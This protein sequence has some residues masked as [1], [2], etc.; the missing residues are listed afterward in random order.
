MPSVSLPAAG[1]AAAAGGAAA[2][3][4]AAA[5]AAVAGTAAAGISASTLATV[6][7]GISAAGTLAAGIASGNAAHYQAQV[8]SNNAKTAQQNQVYSAEAGSS[9]VQQ[10]EMKAGAQDAQVRAAGAASGTD[11]NSGSNADVQTS[12]REIGSLDSATVAGNAAL[13][14]Y[15]YGNQ[16][17]SFAAQSSLDNAEGSFDEA[18]GALKAGGSLLANS[19]FDSTVGFT[20][21]GTS[22][23]S[24]A[25]GAP[26]SLMGGLPSVPS[27]YQWMQQP[28]SGL[29]D[30]Y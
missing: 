9:Q 29:S 10:A 3:G 14:T 12:Q 2:A 25:A 1:T 7:A 5:G 20:P 16:A 28:N 18:S 19:S 6:G 15:G 8:A 13:Q 26:T 22:G 4:T 11:V 17:S 23:V 30:L 24:T 21:S 27:Q